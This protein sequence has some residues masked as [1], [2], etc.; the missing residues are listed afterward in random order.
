L[1]ES[2]PSPLQTAHDL[3][4][5]LQDRDELDQAE[6]ILTR[7][8]ELR[9]EGLGANHPATID[10]AHSI[11]YLRHLSGD[12]GRALEELHGVIDAESQGGR[13]RPRSIL[14]ARHNVARILAAMNRLDEALDVIDLV[15]EESTEL[16]GAENNETAT[17]RHSREFIK[18]L[19]RASNNGRSSRGICQ[20]G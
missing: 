6:T 15:V 20:P 13:P 4:I 19:M 1:G 5:R 9:R 3:A 10:S 11:A 18:E 16:F 12:N 2:H 14:A 17:A 8:F 7:V